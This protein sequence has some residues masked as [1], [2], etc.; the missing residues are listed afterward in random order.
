M[1]KLSV[2]SFQFSANRVLLVTGYWLLATF[3]LALPASAACGSGTNVSCVQAVTAVHGSGVPTLSFP[4][5]GAGHTGIIVMMSNSSLAWTPTSSNGNTWS[6]CSQATWPVNPGTQYFKCWQANN[7]NAGTDSV[8]FGSSNFT[9]AWFVGYEFSGN[10]LTGDKTGNNYQHNTTAIT[11][12]SASVTGTDELVLAVS[13]LPVATS[14]TWTAG[15]SYTQAGTIN[16]TGTGVMLAGEWLENTSA[17]GAQTAAAT[18]SASSSSYTET[19]ILTWKVSAGAVAAPSMSPS[20][21]TY[22]AAQTVTIT[23]STSGATICYTTDGATPGA[24]TAGTCNIDGHTQIYSSG[25]SVSAT[26]TVQA[27]GTKAS[28]A[29]SSVAS[30]AY[31][32]ALPSVALAAENFAWL[33]DAT[34]EAGLNGVGI[35]YQ[36]PLDALWTGGSIGST[37]PVQATAYIGSGTEVSA[38]T[39]NGPNF[40]YPSLDTPSGYGI[41]SYSTTWGYAT[42]TAETYNANQFSKV[43]YHAGGA[44]VAVG[45]HCG[46]GST[47]TGEL[48]TITG[49]AATVQECN[50]G[51]CSTLGTTSFTPTEGD[52]YQLSQYGTVLQPTVNGAQ[53]TGLAATYTGTLAANPPCL[54]VSGHNGGGAALA[55]GY[56]WS[57]GDL[58][59]SSPAIA[60]IAWTP[61][62]YSNY[63]LGASL[64]AFPS[65][66]WFSNGTG[67]LPNTGTVCCN[68]GGVNGSATALGSNNTSGINQAQY[69]APVHDDQWIHAKVLLDSTAWNNRNWFLKIQSQ[70]KMPP[71][72][73]A[74]SVSGCYDPQAIY[75]GDEPMYQNTSAACTSSAEYCGT[76]FLHV[77]YVSDASSTRYPPGAVIRRAGL[78]KITTCSPESDSSIPRW[79]TMKFWQRSRVASCR[80]I[81][82]VAT[83]QECGRLI[84]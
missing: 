60:P 13:S 29:N 16:N 65:W 62:T 14:T 47:V 6:A 31:T 63:S 34:K 37:A 22:F 79:R 40:V 39:V 49:S 27:L 64:P 74:P 56:N 36:F 19:L 84:R 20:A 46:T 3:A 5:V 77:T 9:A 24:T 35:S 23:D 61:P 41:I 71:T 53:I 57:G 48:L 76:N 72:S 50:A 66:P 18:Q 44:S 26:E 1:K 82:R 38:W 4:S 59:V 30:Q 32:I 10:T 52:L 81:A 75:I 33:Y 28:T 45:T 51:S 25:F 42:R 73:L 17:S 68:F 8:T 67:Q 2:F 7:V 58:G 12:S 54:G 15:G 21:G 43:Y 70:S 11:V 80:C 83:V 55:V 69:E 78:P